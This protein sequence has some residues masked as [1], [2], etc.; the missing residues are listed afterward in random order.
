MKQRVIKD[1]S[2]PT[3]QFKS[4]LPLWCGDLSLLIVV[5]CVDMISRLRDLVA[6]FREGDGGSIPGKLVGSGVKS[7]RHGNSAC[8]IIASV[9]QTVERMSFRPVLVR[10]LY[11][12]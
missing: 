8:G 9:P 3:H 6:L 7:V 4:T 10:G 5:A 12:F 2:R 11:A 1:T